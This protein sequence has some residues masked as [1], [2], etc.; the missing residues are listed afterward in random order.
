MKIY[1]VIE[2]LCFL[3]LFLKGSPSLESE[4][5]CGILQTRNG[6][7]ENQQ[8][9]QKLG[10]ICKKGNS[11]L[12]PFTIPSGRLINTNKSYLFTL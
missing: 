11:S 6:K 12:D 4:K 8:C 10:Y 5:I 3:C 9:D 7:W 1:S 2:I